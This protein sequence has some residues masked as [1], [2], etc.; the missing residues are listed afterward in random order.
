MVLSP[1]ICLAEGAIPRP[2]GQEILNKASKNNIIANIC[3]ETG[4]SL[5]EVRFKLIMDGRELERIEM[6]ENLQIRLV[7]KDLYLEKDKQRRAAVFLPT[8]KSTDIVEKD[9][10]NVFINFKD[11]P[12]PVKFALGGIGFATTGSS[13]AQNI[14][15]HYPHPP[16]NGL[17]ACKLPFLKPMPLP[18]IGKAGVVVASGLF[19]TGICSGHID[20]GSLN[21]ESL[22]SLIK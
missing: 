1:V 19:L 10:F 12:T 6:D 20:V 18:V 16:I 8:E 3:E 2:E 7:E 14:A 21:S 15:S 4:M 17:A 22:L 9:N 5:S 11:I 13:V